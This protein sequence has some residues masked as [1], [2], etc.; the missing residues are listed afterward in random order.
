MQKKIKIGILGAAA[1][2]QRS[3]IPAIKNLSNYF[4]LIFIASRDYEKAQ[5][6]A[7]LYNCEAIEGY[8]KLISNPLIEAIYMPLPTGLNKV[9]INKALQNG[10]H[11]YAEK[12]IAMNFIDATEMVSNAKSQNLSLM[13]G[14]MFQYHNQHKIV[15]NLLADNKIGEIRHFTSYFGFPPLPKDNFRYDDKIG[16]G[17]LLDA[18]GYTVRA[19]HFILGKNFK[20]RASSLYYP[21]ESESNILGSAYLSNDKGI[22]A[23]VAFGFDHYYQNRYE[24][25]GSKGKIISER[26]FTPKPDFSPTVIIENNEG[27]NKID[28]SPD[29]HFEKAMI[30]FYESIYSDEKKSLHYENILLQSQTLEQIKLLSKK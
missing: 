1:I 23:S 28:I 12:S 25:W 2:A 19:T 18:A 5:N 4:E 16:G 20:V 22:G 11:V 8:E 21:S 7:N 15:F 26:A 17:A 14:F 27:I 6:L 30:E 10:K 13:E 29:N 24:I 9:W 3:M